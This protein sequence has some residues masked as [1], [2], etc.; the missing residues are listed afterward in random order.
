MSDIPD[1]F[2]EDPADLIQQPIPAAP[3]PDAGLP[4]P[5]PEEVPEFV[6]P[7]LSMLDKIAF[8]RDLINIFR[9]TWKE[10]GGD[11]LNPKEQKTEFVAVLIACGLAV[12]KAT[13]VPSLDMN[14]VLMITGGY[15]AARTT[16]KVVDI[17]TA[18]KANGNGGDTPPAPSQ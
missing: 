15:V 10:E 14:F 4:C 16:K 7:K 3:K 11:R 8:T 17:A 13:Y 9:K 12:L 5:E 1:G 2:K 18:N 6:A